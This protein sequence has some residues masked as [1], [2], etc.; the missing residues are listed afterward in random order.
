MEQRTLTLNERRYR[1]GE[2]HHRA[3]LTDA[4]VDEMREL[5]EEHSVGYRTLAK[6]FNVSK[7][8]VRDIV[9]YK[10]RAQTPEFWVKAKGGGQ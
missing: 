3:K 10:T 2:S 8:T 9:Q 5:H 6:R 4:Q 7:R 1:I